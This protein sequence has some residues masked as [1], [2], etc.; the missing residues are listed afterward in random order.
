MIEAVQHVIAVGA[1]RGVIAHLDP[2]E[3]GFLRDSLVQ[4]SDTQWTVADGRTGSADSLRRLR[5]AAEASLGPLSP[6]EGGPL[7]V[8]REELETI[9]TFQFGAGAAQ[10]L[11]EP[12]VRLHGR[13]WFQ[14]VTDTRGSDLA[15]W[16]EERGLFQ[17]TV[18]GGT[19]MMEAHPLE[20]EV[21]PEVPMAGDLFVPGVAKADPA[22]RTGDAV[23]L[24]R[25]GKLLAVGEAA[26]PGPLMGQLGRGLAVRLRH[27]ARAPESTTA[28]T[29]P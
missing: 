22:I 26:L 10:R 7:A 23:L 9:A 19:R 21:R 24:V 14:R 11:F 16:R 3:Y 27:R 2:E 13:P 18:A 1:Y 20:V 29:G 25:D 12:P 17:S 15:T 28:P 5:E 4:R 6:V 8:V